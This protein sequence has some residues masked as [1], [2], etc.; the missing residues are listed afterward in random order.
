M[1]PKMRPSFPDIVKRLDK[2][3]ACPKVEEMEHGVAKI[4]GDDDNKQT[5]PK[6]K[7]TSKKR[8]AMIHL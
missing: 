2:I 6:G 5:I 8:D 1:N 7:T 4:S 3:L